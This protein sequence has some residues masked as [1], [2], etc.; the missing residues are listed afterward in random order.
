MQASYVFGL[1][2]RTGGAPRPIPTLEAYPFWNF[3]DFTPFGCEPTSEEQ[4]KRIKKKRAE[5]AIRASLLFWLTIQTQY[6][7][8]NLFCEWV[9]GGAQQMAGDRIE[10]DMESSIKAINGIVL[11]LN[12]GWR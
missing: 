12:G 11:P 8:T 9:G 3:I 10:N 4:K 2:W 1:R 5:K 6:K 7:I